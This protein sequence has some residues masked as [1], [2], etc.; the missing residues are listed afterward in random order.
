MDKQYQSM[1]ESKTNRVTS[2][3]IGVPEHVFLFYLSL[4]RLLLTKRY[5]YIFLGLQPTLFVTHVNPNSL[6]SVPKRTQPHRSTWHENE[7]DG[8]TVG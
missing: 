6:T 1:P 8:T 2:F 4:L 5:Y 3:G 7:D